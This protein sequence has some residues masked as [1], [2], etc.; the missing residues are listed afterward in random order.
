MI[1]LLRYV[2]VLNSKSDK[3]HIKERI[4]NYDIHYKDEWH[5]LPFITILATP[6]QAEYLE[7]QEG[8]REVRL[9]TKI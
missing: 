8:V 1:Q 2:V 9:S 3:G 4:E 5:I 6:K 7:H